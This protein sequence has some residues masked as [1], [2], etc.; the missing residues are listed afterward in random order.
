MNAITKEDRTLIIVFTLIIL[1]AMTLICV[2]IYYIHTDNIAATEFCESIK[3]KYG[4]EDNSRVCY[5]DIDDTRYI[6]KIVEDDGK[7]R[8]LK[9]GEA[10]R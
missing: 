10:L 1:L 8:L 7:Y 2:M 3:M 4:A 9:S 6:I 5:N